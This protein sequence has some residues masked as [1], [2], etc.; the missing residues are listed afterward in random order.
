MM[1]GADIIKA[2]FLK[3]HNSLPIVHPPAMDSELGKAFSF[4]KYLRIL[5]NFLAVKGI[6]N[7]PQDIL[8]KNLIK[9]FLNFVCKSH[10]VE[11]VDCDTIGCQK[12][13]DRNTWNQKN[14]NAQNPQNRSEEILDNIFHPPFEEHKQI[15]TPLLSHIAVPDLADFSCRADGIKICYQNISFENFVKNYFE[16]R[17]P[18]IKG[19]VCQ[20]I[21]IDSYL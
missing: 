6:E 18:F 21:V 10:T 11:L 13:K 17:D 16:K 5:A 1:K 9:E 15:K 20:W 12:P 2:V 19:E 4:Q 7:C 3:P 14:K 8:V